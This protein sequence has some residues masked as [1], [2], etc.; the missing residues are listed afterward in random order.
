MHHS[1]KY[2]GAYKEYKKY[3]QK[4]QNQNREVLRSFLKIQPISVN[5]PPLILDTRPALYANPGSGPSILAT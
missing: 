4:Q 3:N 1:S 2:H 5:S